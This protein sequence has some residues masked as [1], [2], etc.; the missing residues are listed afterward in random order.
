M[1]SYQVPYPVITPTPHLQ[2]HSPLRRKLQG[3]VAEMFPYEMEQPIK[4][5]MYH[6]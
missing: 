2:A 1:T 6:Q 5:L 4:Y 3:V